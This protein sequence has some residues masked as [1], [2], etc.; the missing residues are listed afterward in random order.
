MTHPSKAKGN[1]YERELVQAAEAAGLEAKRAWGSNGQALGHHNAVD[2]LVAGKRIQA[3][4]R[5]SIP[6]WLSL[7]PNVDA[8]AVREDRGQTVVL[9]PFLEYLKLLGGLAHD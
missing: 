6:A 2:L 8:V 5:K 1:G 4:R 9:V 7:T 3:K